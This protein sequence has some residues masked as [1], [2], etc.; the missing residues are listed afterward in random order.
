MAQEYWQWPESR[1]GSS[2]IDW[3]KAGTITAGIDVG[4]VSS[5][6]VVMCD[7]NLYCYAN[8]YTGPDS[9]GSANRAMEMA[10][11]GTGLKIGDI[12]SAVATGYGRKNV[13]FAQQTVNEINCHARGARFMY[14]PTVRTI[15]DLGGQ[16]SKVIKC[17][18][19]GNIVEFY[20]SDK[21][22]TGMGRG[23]E[24]LSKL[25]HV[26]LVDMGELSLT[27]EKDPDPVSNTC[28]IYANTEAMGLFRG[29]VKENEALA[30]Y[31][32]AVA[33][34]LFILAGRVKVEQDIALTGGL[35]KN[36]GI[37]K[38]LERLLGMNVLTSD[39]DTQ[40]AGAI[41][42]ALLAKERL[43]EPRQATAGVK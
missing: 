34:R 40:L 12:R 7:D 24:L 16:A 30:A 25:M 33:Y 2:D 29:G 41:G 43:E 20:F 37:V 26:P 39:Y 32:Y 1:W 6:A 36:T 13:P 31:L 11:G 35:A 10:L 21:C 5:Q 3:K 14:G 38:R 8:I 9:G 28:Y 17:T 27:V 18:D 15:I 19:Y 42:A 22:A 23:I 4:A